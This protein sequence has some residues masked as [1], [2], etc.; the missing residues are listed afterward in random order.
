MIIHV[1]GHCCISLVQAMVMA[2]P[3]LLESLHVNELFSSATC[4]IWYTTLPHLPRSH[5]EVAGTGSA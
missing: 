4:K 5:D 2:D 3:V 1:V